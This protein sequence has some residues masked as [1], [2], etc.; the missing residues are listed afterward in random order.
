MTLLI[1]LA[2]PV[3]YELSIP[4]KR[5]HPNLSQVG[6]LFRTNANK[7]RPYFVVLSG[8]V[9]AEVIVVEVPPMVEAESVVIMVDV[10]SAIVLVSSVFLLLEQ[11]VVSASIDNAKKADWMMVFIGR[12]V[13]VSLPKLVTPINIQTHKR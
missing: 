11:P 1:R 5:Q 4:F 9:V 6:V 12:S 10:E 8:V 2:I 7:T 3:Q 13:L